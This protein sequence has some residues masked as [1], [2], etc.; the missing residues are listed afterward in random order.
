[1]MIPN[2]QPVQG[3]FIGSHRPVLNY[4][5]VQNI[6]TTSIGAEQAYQQYWQETVNRYNN[7]H[8]G[9]SPTYRMKEAIISMAT[10]GPGNKN[11]AGN[12]EAERV[13]DDF[14]ET[15]RRV[16][17]KDLGFT[18]LGVR[19]PDI[20]MVTKTGEFVL[21]SASGGIM[22]LVDLTWQIFLYSQGKSD[23][24]VLLDEPENHLHPSMQRSLLQS[25]VGAFP[26]ARFVVATHSPFVVSSVRDANVYVLRHKTDEM[27][28]AQLRSVSS[29]LLDQTSR[30]GTASDIL[31]EALGV[32]VT[33][34]MWAEAELRQISNDFHIHDLGELQVSTL[35][36][37]LEDAGLAE[38]YPDA[39]S[40]I[41]R[42]A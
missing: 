35:K 6:P 16:L 17:P 37:R 28:A 32:P 7:G 2:Q 26:A 33:M 25:L 36:Q 18:E 41:A 21:D 10:F 13:F 4:Q 29:T 1:V 8:T 12:K 11:V 24:I 38:F 27:D 20:V 15:L 9:Y 22:S 5:P 23:F 3:L 39:L 31:R 19:I 14:E 42:R 30:A 40:D 34:P